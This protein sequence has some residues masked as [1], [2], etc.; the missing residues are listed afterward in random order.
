[1][2]EQQ[3]R[4]IFRYRDNAPKGG[5]EVILHVDRFGQF[6]GSIVW[7][8]V[9]QLG[10]EFLEEPEHIVRDLGDAVL[11]VAA[12]GQKPTSSA[13]ADTAD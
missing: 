8:E 13:T 6:A 5:P 9:E 1:M 4:R 3:I 7:Q 2:V 10:I 11:Q 12:S